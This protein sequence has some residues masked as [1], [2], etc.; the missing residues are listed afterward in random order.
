MMDS[1]RTGPSAVLESRRRCRGAARWRRRQRRAAV[2]PVPFLE[3]EI[4]SDAELLPSP[5]YH[6][7]V[8]SEGTRCRQVK[9][10]AHQPADL[11]QAGFGADSHAEGIGWI[12]FRMNEDG[13]DA[14]ISTSLC[15]G[16]FLLIRS[17]AMA[18]PPQNGKIRIQVGLRAD[19]VLLDQR[20]A[21]RSTFMVGPFKDPSRAGKMSRGRPGGMTGTCR[22]RGTVLVPERPAQLRM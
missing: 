2:D 11:P 10:A 13:K 8:E 20:E 19:V 9:L 3:H 5:V 7:P 4:S 6:H 15:R 12:D 16:V 18:W 22:V 1:G 17:Q 21:P 14:R